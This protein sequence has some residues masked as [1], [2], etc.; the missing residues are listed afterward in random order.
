MTNS[1]LLL[2]G[3]LVL[4]ALAAIAAIVWF[5]GGTDEPS[6]PIAATPIATAETQAGGSAPTAPN[7][8]TPAA[9]ATQ[10][11]SDTPTAP[12]TDTPAAAATPE[13]TDAPAAS[14]T[15]TP[16][17]AT[18]APAA[19][20]ATVFQ[21][22]QAESEA[23]FTM[24]E[25]LRGSPKTVGGVTD[26][27]AG[28]LAVNPSDPQSAQVGV[29]QVNARTLVTDADMR[30]RAIRRF[31]LQTDDYEF[32]TFEPSAIT[33]LPDSVAVGES[34]DFQISS[35]PT[36]RDIT[37]EVTFVVSITPVSETR[38]AGLASTTILRADYNL[39]IPSVPSVA[40]VDEEVLVEL[41]FVAEETD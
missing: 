25:L 11:S 13:S 35:D 36:I 29:I 14:D 19:S 32:I 4:V 18:D 2:I 22:V 24:D 5:S 7:T 8:D 1:R 12:A 3:V 17:A 16:V 34:F 9:V 31:I 39:T 41:E 21:I 10:R 38:L 20:M 28:E 33:G 6:A 15:S 27:V 40:D 26:Q 30:N 37:N 23:R